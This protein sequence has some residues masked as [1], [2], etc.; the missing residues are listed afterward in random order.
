MYDALTSRRIY[1]EPISHQQAKNII[2]R[3][4]GSHFDP[5]IVKSFL[6]CEKQFIAI[7]E[8][9]GEMENERRQKV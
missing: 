2:V 7:R 4:S 8:S 1:K 3:E 9:L 5:S 6:A